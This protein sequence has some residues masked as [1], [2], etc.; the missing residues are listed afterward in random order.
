MVSWQVVGQDNDHGF[1][2]SRS[3][4]YFVTKFTHRDT[5]YFAAA[6]GEKTGGKYQVDAGTVN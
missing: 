3:S 4:T 6:S 2:S 5:G 1:G